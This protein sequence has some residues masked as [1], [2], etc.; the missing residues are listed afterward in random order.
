MLEAVSEKARRTLFFGLKQ[1]TRT[2]SV[3][4]IADIPYG[5]LPEQRV[6]L[7]M[8]VNAQP[9]Y[10]VIFIHGG[11]WQYGNKDEYAFMGQSL[12]RRGIATLVMDYRLYPVA[13]YPAFV[14]DAARMLAWHATSSAFYGLENRPLYLM[15]HSAG[16]HIAMLA[17]MDPDFASQYGFSVPN[18]KGIIS[19][20]GVYSFRPEKSPV[21]QK[22]FPAEQC[23]ENYRKVKPVNFVRESGVPL[24]ILH[25][26]KDTTVACRSAERMYKNALLAGH[27][28]FLKVREN[29]GHYALLFD[30]VAYSP[31]H[32]ATLGAIE[33]FMQDYS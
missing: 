13:D 22:I 31:G 7:Y 16:A 3:S 21:Y 29:D 33:T 32:E 6:D 26:R 12:A 14:E 20:A 8:P 1:I 28:V 23:G 25:G 11:S 24:Y 5:N 18:V 27:P 4:C 2:R 30:F 19:L 10:T 15:G 17:V 9:R